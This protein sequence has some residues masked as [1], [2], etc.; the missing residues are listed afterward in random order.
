[1]FGSGNV[2]ASKLG[3]GAPALPSPMDRTG[4]VCPVMRAGSLGDSL[5]P[6][7]GESYLPSTLVGAVAKPTH[8]VASRSISQRLGVSLRLKFVFGAHATC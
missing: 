5:T 6:V 2:P 7:A 1:M 3:E 8:D 4:S